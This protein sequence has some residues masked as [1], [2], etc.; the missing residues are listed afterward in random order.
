MRALLLALALVLGPAAH[1]APGFAP[2]LGAQVPLS[3]PAGAAADLGDLTEGRPALVLAGYHECPNLCGTAQD[4]AIRALGDSGLGPQDYR[5]L[6]LGVD[7][8]ETPAQAAQTLARLAGDH[9]PEAVAP[10]R[11]PTGPEAAALA[12]RLGMASEAQVRTGE[13][14]H[15]VGLVA[16]SPEGR[17]A[18]VLPGIGW[19]P[20]DLRLALVEA[21][22]GR[23]GGLPDR[24]LLF[25]AGFDETQGQYTST[26]AAGLRLAGWATLALMALGIGALVWR[27]RRR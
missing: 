15:P 25:C 26:V 4:A 13:F 22:E 20:R 8:Q 19:A 24:V 23:V 11:A 27:E 16:L 17:I 12:V 2:E 1:A 14:I 6:F 21:S 3:T 5:V 18:R 7:P 10:W 9:G